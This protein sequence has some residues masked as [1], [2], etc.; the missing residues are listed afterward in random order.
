M[1]KN[2]YI[3]ICLT[4]LLCYNNIV[5]QLYFNKIK[6]K[7]N[8]SWSVEESFADLS[9]FKLNATLKIISGYVIKT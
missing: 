9:N 6:N 3:Y 7:K 5:N 2:I 4:E 8:K 1:K